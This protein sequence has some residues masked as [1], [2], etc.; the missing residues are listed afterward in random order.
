MCVIGSSL[1]SK[2]AISTLEFMK[3]EAF[4][5]LDLDNHLLFVCELF[6]WCVTFFMRKW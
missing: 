5:V 2:E 3:L 1:M 6:Q 4:Y